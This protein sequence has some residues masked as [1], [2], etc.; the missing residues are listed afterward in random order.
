MLHPA[1]GAKKHAL[2]AIFPSVPC[3]H[4]VLAANTVHDHHVMLLDSANRLQQ[5]FVA[6]PANAQKESPEQIELI[7]DDST[8]VHKRA[9]VVFEAHVK[10]DFNHR[11]LC[12]HGTCPWPFGPRFRRLHLLRCKFHEYVRPTT[13]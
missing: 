13:G 6:M 2:R 1:G 9:S 12:S 4:L 7:G 11:A 8:E 5:Y 3:R 10:V